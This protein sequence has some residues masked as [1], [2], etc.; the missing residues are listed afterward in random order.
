MPGNESSPPSAPTPE[1]TSPLVNSPPES[2]S[3]PTPP[4]GETAADPSSSKSNPISE[5]PK[6]SPNAVR[7][8][9]PKPPKATTKP[10]APKP[11]PEPK[12]EQPVAINRPPAPPHDPVLGAAGREFLAWA[13]EHHT[14]D[15][16]AAYYAH[17]RDWLAE[18]YAG[19]AELAHVLERLA[20]L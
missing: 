4:T 8:Q 15:E 10:T 20:K 12:V 7:P 1:Q 11:D 19:D 2:Q 16:F 17:R 13:G 14:D 3:T 18:K 5:S 9:S 6:T